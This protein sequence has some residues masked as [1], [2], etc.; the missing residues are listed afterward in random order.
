MHLSWSR[1][2]YP[3]VSFKQAQPVTKWSNS[4][5]F[6]PEPQLNHTLSSNVVAEGSYTF[7]KRVVSF[8]L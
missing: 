2:S 1:Y 3:L 4:N 7:S 6:S 8:F 5:Y